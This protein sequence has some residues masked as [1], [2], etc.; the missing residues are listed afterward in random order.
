MKIDDID[1]IFTLFFCTF[2]IRD[3]RATKID[4]YIDYNV[5]FCIQVGTKR[6]LAP[7]ILDETL[8]VNHF[9]SW[10]RADVYSLG[11]VYW[12]LG[13]RTSIPGRDVPEFQLPYHEVVEPDPTLDEMKSVV[14][15]KE[16]RPAIPEHWQENEVR[17]AAAQVQ[18]PQ[19][20]IFIVSLFFCR[21]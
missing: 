6:Y 19:Y 13:M 3:S 17:L 12:E 5:P 9:D 7:E 20:L 18:E 11:L 2:A 10:K 1:R 8:N 15:I 16:V 14:C 4:L 21:R